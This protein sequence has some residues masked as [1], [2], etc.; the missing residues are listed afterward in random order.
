MQAPEC[1]IPPE[2]GVKGG[3]Q[4]SALV[5]GRRIGIVEEQE[6]LSNAEH[7]SSLYLCIS[8]C[9]VCLQRPEEGI[10]SQELELHIGR[11]SHWLLV[12]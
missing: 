8:I 3:S 10:R 6:V 2:A 9:C 5:P 1:W 7:L 4:L 11:L 12:L